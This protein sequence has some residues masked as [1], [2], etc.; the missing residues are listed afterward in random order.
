MDRA[1]LCNQYPYSFGTKRSGRLL[2]EVLFAR[3]S[4]STKSVHREESEDRANK[5][6]NLQSSVAQTNLVDSGLIEE[7]ERMQPGL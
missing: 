2:T 1:V 6:A 3:F 5:R 7:A 4:P